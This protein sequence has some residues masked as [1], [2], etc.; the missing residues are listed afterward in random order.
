MGLDPNQYDADPAHSDADPDTSPNMGIDPVPAPNTS[1]KHNLNPELEF[2]K[3]NP[4]PRETREAFTSFHLSPADPTDP[5]QIVQIANFALVYLANISFH[6]M[7]CDFRPI[8]MSFTLLK[9]HL[10]LNKGPI[11]RRK[12]WKTNGIKQGRMENEYN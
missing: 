6:F 2:E 11:G 9:S 8:C 7:P 3:T 4:A 12:G 5:L 10:H 1:E